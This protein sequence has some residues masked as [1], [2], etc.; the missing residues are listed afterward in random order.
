MPWSDSDAPIL[1]YAE[2]SLLGA[3]VQ[4]KRKGTDPLRH[5]SIARVLNLPPPFGP[6]PLLTVTFALD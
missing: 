3:V 5:G 6:E 1:N 2:S 4:Y